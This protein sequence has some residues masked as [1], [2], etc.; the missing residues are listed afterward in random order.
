[1][2]LKTL[3]YRITSLFIQVG[4]RQYDV[5]RVPTQTSYKC[6]KPPKTPLKT[7]KNLKNYCKVQHFSR[8]FRWEIY[9]NN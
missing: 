9:L 2:E 5:V 1:M 8:K 7:T 3:F 4:E 6:K